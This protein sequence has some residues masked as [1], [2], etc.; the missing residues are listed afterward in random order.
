MAINLKELTRKDRVLVSVECD[1]FFLSTNKTKKAQPI[2]N[3]LKSKTKLPKRFDPELW[4]IITMVGKALVSGCRG[5]QLTLSGANYTFVNASR[6]NNLDHRRARKVLDTLEEMGY[7]QLFI[8]YKDFKR[9]ISIMSCVLFSE[10][11]IQLFPDNIVKSYGRSITLDEMVE[12]KDSKTKLPL[13]KLTRFKGVGA[14]KQ[15]MWDYNSLLQQHDIRLGSKKCFVQYKQVFADDL[16]GAGRVYSFGSF[17]TMQGYLREV[18]TIDGQR[19]TEV[20]IKANHISMMYLLEGV[21]LDK[22]FDCYDVDLYGYEYKDTRAL[23]KMAVMCMIN[24]K[25]SVGAAKAL[26]K[27]VQDD[28]EDT[29]PYLLPFHDRDSDF[30]QLVVNLLKK[31]HDRLDFFKRGEILWKKLQRLDSKVMEGVLQHFTKKG[32]VVLGWHDSWVIRRPLRNELKRVIEDSW[33]H[34]FG[35]YDNCFIKVEF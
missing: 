7:I 12:I 4:M 20:D 27:I 1:S 31:K 8:G 23:C 11:L 35:T 10:E 30:F 19:C 6:Q 29:E 16:D 14:N 5:S 17:Q 21:K 25:S 9:D 13:A 3:K 28:Q 34:V 26:Q 15:F 32:E 22:D 33:F 24:C 18:I 2:F